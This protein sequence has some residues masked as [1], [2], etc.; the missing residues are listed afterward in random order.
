[1]SIRSLR[2]VRRW[3][4]LGGLTL[5]FLIPAGAA[6]AQTGGGTN[7]IPDPGTADPCGGKGLPVIGQVNGVDVCGAASAQ[8]VS[9]T[10]ATSGSMAF[11][12]ANIA[13]LVGLGSVVVVG[14]VLLVRLSRRPAAT[15]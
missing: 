14:G 11:T 5:L 15:R 7:Y 12:G 13:F 2:S 8:R 6:F 3:L 4:A 1:M 10:S 9:T